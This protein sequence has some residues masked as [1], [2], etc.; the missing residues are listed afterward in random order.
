MIYMAQRQQHFNSDSTGYIVLIHSQILIPSIIVPP[1]NT[2]FVLLQG[3]R[4][5]F[6]FVLRK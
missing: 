3:M 5:F 2:Q 4:L 6:T 1:N